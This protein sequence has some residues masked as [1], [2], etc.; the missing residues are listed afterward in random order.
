MRKMMS[1]GLALSVVA[2]AA[3]APAYSQA[4]Q[5]R[6]MEAIIAAV[7]ANPSDLNLRRELAKAMILRGQTVKAVEQMRA[8]MNAGSATA[9][10]YTTLGDALR[11]SADYRN[12]IQAY[13]NAL[14]MTPMNTQA[15]GGLALAYAQSGNCAQGMSIVRT[16]L[17]QTTDSQGRQYLA[18]TMASIQNMSTI[19]AA[20]GTTLQ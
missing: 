14:R 11:Y 18:S 3:V 19:A 20:P 4:P 12:A 15:L 1:L 17:S 9:D 2:L 7:R 5:Q 8:V 13:T 6:S 10:D 16:G